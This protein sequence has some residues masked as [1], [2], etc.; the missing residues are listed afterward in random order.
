[1]DPKI[2]VFHVE[3][4]KIMRDGVKHLLGQDEE[5]D[6]VGEA[7]AGEELLDQLKSKPADVV[8]LDL[9]LDAMEDLQQMNGFELCK[10]I[11]EKFERTK[12]VAHSVYDDADRVARILKAGASGF[13][14]KKSGI[15]ELRHAVKVVHTGK[16]YICAETSK[17]LKNLNKFLMGIEDNLR[18]KDELFSLREREVLELL[19]QGRS[20]KEI[21]G[22]LFITE[23]T[24]DT[25]RKN[26][27]EK[28]QVKNTVELL[29]YASSLGLVKK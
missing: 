2:R 27:I 5:I 6:M 14:S 22:S 3:D 9:Y 26:M 15:E 1:M 17:R 12:I 19:A 13:V 8:I 25:H 18:S 11:L 21:A 24:V 16:V 7:R 4:Y 29:V 20:S 28:A 23:R 10:L